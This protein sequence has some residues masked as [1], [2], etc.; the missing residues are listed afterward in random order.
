MKASIA[1]LLVAVSASAETMP[2]TK[3]DT[4]IHFADYMRYGGIATYRLLDWKTTTDGI[5]IGAHE[6][7]IPAS[8]AD[9]SGR[10]AMF[11]AGMTGAQVGV[12]VLLIK[13]NHRRIAQTVDCLSIGAGMLFV[14]HNVQTIHTTES[15]ASKLVKE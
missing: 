10:L 11:E 4:T 3:P 12:S 5:H 1:L 15:N 9:H 13:H 6:V 2:P 8:I 14:A 7:V